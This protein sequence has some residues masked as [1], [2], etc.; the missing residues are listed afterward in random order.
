M[1]EAGV[2]ALL[3]Y[4][5]REDRPEW[6]VEAVYEAMRCAAYRGKT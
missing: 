4:D 3:D 2:N 6:I 5:V 1:V